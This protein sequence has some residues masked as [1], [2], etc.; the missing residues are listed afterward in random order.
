MDSVFIFR[1]SLSEAWVKHCFDLIISLNALGTTFAAHSRV[2]ET[3]N[4]IGEV[5]FKAILRE[6]ASPTDVGMAY[7]WSVSLIETPL[8]SPKPLSSGL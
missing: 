7:A 3:V 4:R 8:L 1:E 2:L 6:V 5:E